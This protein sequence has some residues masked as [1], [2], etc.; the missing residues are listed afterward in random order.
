MSNYSRMLQGVGTE[1][2]IKNL[3]D[4]DINFICNLLKGDKSSREIGLIY[5]NMVPKIRFDTDAVV[6][7]WRSR[8]TNGQ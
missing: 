2:E 8:F 7:A 6:R 3:S 1:E 5:E 4:A